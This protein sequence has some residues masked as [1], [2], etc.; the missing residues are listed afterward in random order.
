[1]GGNSWFASAIFMMRCTDTLPIAKATTA[2]LLSTRRSSPSNP[3][4]PSTAAQKQNETATQIEHIRTYILRHSRTVNHSVLR[5]VGVDAQDGLQQAVEQNL[6]VD[7]AQR[8]S[9]AL[10]N[11]FQGM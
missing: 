3:S 10:G 9:V 7:G 6:R 11:R 8:I 5:L 1:L 4:R 2:T